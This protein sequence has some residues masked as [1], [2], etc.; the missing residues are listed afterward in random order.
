V[1]DTVPALPVEATPAL[2]RQAAR[3]S[4]T[5]ADALLEIKPAIYVSA[6]LGVHVGRDRKVRCPFHADEHPSLHVYPTA[7]Q[8]WHCFSCRRGG[9]IYDL[10]GELMGL[11][12]RGVAFLQLRAQLRQRLLGSAA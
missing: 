10:A 12:T 7:A 2:R 11:P 8:G 5:G 4:T 3:E 6:L 9:S 1:L